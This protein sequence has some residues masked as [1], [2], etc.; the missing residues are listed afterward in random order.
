VSVCNVCIY[1]YTHTHTHMN[2]SMLLP[3][4]TVAAVVNSD[5]QVLK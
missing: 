5:V 4:Y 2:L 1:L 3:V